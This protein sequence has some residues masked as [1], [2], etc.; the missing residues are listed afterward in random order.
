MDRKKKSLVTVWTLDFL[1]LETSIFLLE[2][3]LWMNFVD[4][5]FHKNPETLT[6]LFT[7]PFSFL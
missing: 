5:S 3:F 4:I 6:I 7:D 1:D 2:M